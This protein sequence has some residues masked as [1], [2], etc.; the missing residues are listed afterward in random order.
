MTKPSVYRASRIAANRH[1]AFAYVRSPTIFCYLRICI[2]SRGIANQHH[3]R[4]LQ[5]WQFVWGDFHATRRV[6]FSS[7]SIIW[8]IFKRRFWAKWGCQRDHN[9]L[10]RSRTLHNLSRKA[11][12]PPNSHV[13]PTSPNILFY[14]CQLISVPCRAHGKARCVQFVFLQFKTDLHQIKTFFLFA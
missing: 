13:L 11:P 2:T 14:T 4:F 9:F 12:D 3:E 8:N 7:L 6:D 5:N 1:Y 10:T